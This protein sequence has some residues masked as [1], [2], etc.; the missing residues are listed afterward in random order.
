[1]RVL[2]D[3]NI[4]LDVLLKRPPFFADSSAVVAR[5]VVRGIEM[6]IAW[7]GLAT[8]YYFLKRGLREADA[9]VEVDRIFSWAQVASVTDAAARRARSLGFTDFEDALQ[10]VAAESC[11][12]DWL[13]T[14]NASDFRSSGVP[15]ITPEEFLQR[16]PAP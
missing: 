5:C 14:R 2:L 9:L 15:A 16:V 8:A 1:M 11:S 3:T 13:V 12:A 7:H 4:L 10:A 6:W